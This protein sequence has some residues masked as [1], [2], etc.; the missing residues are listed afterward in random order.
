MLLYEWTREK[1]NNNPDTKGL[2]FL[3]HPILNITD[4]QTCSNRVIKMEINLHGKDSVT[5]INAYV[6]TSS[7]EDEKMQ[8][9]YNDNE[10]AMADSDSRYK[11]IT[12][13]FN[14]K[15]ELKQKKKTSKAYRL[16]REKVKG[17]NENY[18]TILEEIYTGATTRVHM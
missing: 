5:E 1:H 11:I 2:A 17:M 12:R 13:D 9:L 15:L 8:Q 3:I 6:P 10:R 14:A 16:Q 7:P 18:I 4:F